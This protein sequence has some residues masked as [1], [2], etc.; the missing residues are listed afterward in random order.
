VISAR[1]RALSGAV[2]VVA[3]SGSWMAAGARPAAA[4]VCAFGIETTPG[5]ILGSPSVRLTGP[6]V[7]KP[8]TGVRT[9]EVS[10]TRSPGAA[11]ASASRSGA[12]VGPPGRFDVTAG[13]LALNGRYTARVRAIHTETSLFNCD[14]GLDNGRRD[15]ESSREV[16]FGVSV[17]AAPPT[18][19][20]ALFDAGP[21]RTATVTWD[22]SGDPDIAG[23]IV[24]RKVGSDPPTAGRAIPATPLSWTDD[25]LPGGAASVTYS[26][27]A[28]R[29]GPDPG[30]TSE[31]SAPV[32]AAT[33]EVPP[34]PPPP[35]TTTG[36]ITGGTGGTGGTTGTTRV[37]QTTPTTAPFVL[38]RAVAPSATSPPGTFPPLRLPSGLGG[39]GSSNN[40]S[41]P[42][43]DGGYEPVLPYR[44]G[45]GEPPVTMPLEGAGAQALAAGENGAG[46]GGGTPQLAYVA[47]GLLSSVIAAHVLW[48]RKQVGRPDAPGPGGPLPEL[49][50]LTPPPSVVTAA[51]LKPPTENAESPFEP[52][53]PFEPS[54]PTDPVPS[55]GPARG[56]VILL[57]P[58]AASPP[59]NPVLP[60]NRPSEPDGGGQAD[61]PLVEPADR[62]PI[63]LRPIGR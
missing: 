56:G 32:S 36:G 13:P 33:L 29:N 46:N 37:T 39:A 60:P 4:Y 5:S 44:P 38:G 42:E 63:V 40:P 34:P 49:E 26:V 30:T 17:R 57:P 1:G 21:P 12:D 9:V 8:T 59:A 35:T 47:S 15:T 23:Y 19:V 52:V 20:K 54:P 58:R 28:A 61:G 41:S 31:Y 48:L 3:F 10:F 25:N 6:F 43:A 24:R 14:G 50:P 11:P 53:S 2:A 16:S 55:S 62:R 27:Q 7:V 22:K 51:N 45:S 18:N